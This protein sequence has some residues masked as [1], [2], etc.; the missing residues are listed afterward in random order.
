MIYIEYISRRA[1]VELRDFHELMTKGQDGWDAGFQ[2]DRLVLGAA[3]TWRMGPE[4]EHLGV[5]QSPGFGFERIDDWERIFRSGA[6][7]HLEEPFRKVARIDAAGCYDALLEPVRARNGNY[8]AEFFKANGELS[9]IRSFYQ[10]RAK[11]HQNLTL[12]LLVHRIGRL[13]PEPG[14]LAVW[15]LP[16]FAALA[17]IAR[18]LDGVRQPIQLEAAGTYADVGKQ[19]L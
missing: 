18:E 7:D 9:A 15:T 8:Y 2:E 5:W 4:P 13:G 19:M 11:K 10:E 3:R 16:N 14:G 6:A 1:G 17:E 12:N